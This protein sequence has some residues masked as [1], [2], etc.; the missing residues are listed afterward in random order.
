MVQESNSTE[1]KLEGEQER[2]REDERKKGR[3]RRSSEAGAKT[4]LAMTLSVVKEANVL[5]G[6]NG[7]CSNGRS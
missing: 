2:R 3:R 6:D 7:A 5:A 4:E 1:Q